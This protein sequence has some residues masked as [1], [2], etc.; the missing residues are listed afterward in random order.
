MAID[1]HQMAR[2][3]RQAK[4]FD[5]LQYRSTLSQFEFH[6][7]GLARIRRQVVLQR[8]EE[9]EDNPHAITGLPLFAPQLD[10]RP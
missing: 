7:I 4:A 5:Q 9:L 10:K 3:L 1:Q 2:S 6:R 8:S